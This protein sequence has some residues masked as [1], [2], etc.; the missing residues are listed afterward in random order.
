MSGGIWVLY[1]F[2]I[3]EQ[4]CST[5]EQ[6]RYY[7][8]LIFNTESK[9]SFPIE[10]L[11]Q[12]VFNKYLWLSLHF[13]GRLPCTKWLC[14][15]NLQWFMYIAPSTGE[16]ITSSYSVTGRIMQT[17]QQIGFSIIY[18]SFWFCCTHTESAWILNLYLPFLC[19]WPK[20]T[21][22]HFCVRKKLMEILGIERKWDS[23]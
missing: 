12:E 8:V 9:F 1:N 22:C 18:R 13:H 15:S 4:L 7:K 16:T 6:W 2:C 19:V 5:G 21:Y 20:S 11:G 3:L 14:R 17:L 10:Y 23:N